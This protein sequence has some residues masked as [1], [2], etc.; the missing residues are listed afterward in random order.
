MRHQ[1][2]YVVPSFNRLK[3]PD[4]HRIDLSE[5]DLR[6]LFETPHNLRDGK[7]V[8][9]IWLCNMSGMGYL[10][11]FSVHAFLSRLNAPHDCP[12][13]GIDISKYVWL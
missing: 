7:R 13:A 4:T 5:L 8:Q 1:L 3:S 9:G 2:L 6:I 12:A 11:A 10:G